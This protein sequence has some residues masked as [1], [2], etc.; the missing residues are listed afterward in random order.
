MN[1]PSHG[2]VCG[3]YRLNL[4]RPLIMAIV[5]LTTDSFSGD[6]L[7]EADLEQVAARAE[8]AVAA[9]AAILDVGGESTRPGAEPVA[10]DEEVVRVIPVVERLKALGVPISVDTMKPTVMRAAIAA[11]AAMIN[12]VNA[13]R[14]PG[15]VDA[16]AGSGVG[17]CVMHM[18][19]SSRDM[20]EAPSYRE[21]VVTEVSAFL[22]NRVVELI[23]AGVAAEHICVDPGFGFGK[24]LAHNLE[25]LRRLELLASHGRPLLVGLSRKS[26]LGALTG[27][28]T[29]AR[30]YASVA[31]AVLAVER[32]ARILR[33]HDV[34]ATRDAL[35]VWE[36][37]AGR[38]S[39]SL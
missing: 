32:G 39:P 11:G 37:V 30:V 35:R 25:L 10:E 22:Q 4:D 13:F 6:G 2:L 9:G 14:A 29:N 18:Q 24:T 8:A 3:P 34:A 20:Q 33:V 7:A 23:G 16:V 27:Q 31:A 36:G 21:D 28:P 17:L 38:V 26:M 5:N 15:A 19:G 12:D 1:L